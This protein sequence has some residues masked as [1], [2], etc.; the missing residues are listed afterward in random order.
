MLSQTIYNNLFRYASKSTLPKCHAAVVIFDG[1][2]SAYGYNHFDCKG[3]SVHAEA[4]AV[5]RFL[6]QFQ[7]VLEVK[8]DSSYNIKRLTKK[9]RKML[10]KV[11]I[12]VLRFSR[13]NSLLGNSMP[14]SECQKTLLH[15]G[16]TKIRYSTNDQEIVSRK[17]SDLPE[18]FSRPSKYYRGGRC[19]QVF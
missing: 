1:K 3:R 11:K 17:I 14:C 2:A 4:H 19:K 6:K 10:K 16:V 18:H 5:M 15:C 9:E 13:G 8:N 12:V 7:T